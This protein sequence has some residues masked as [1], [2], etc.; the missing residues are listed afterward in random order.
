[1]VN[2][3]IERDVIIIGSERIEEKIKQIKLLMSELENSEP[4]LYKIQKLE[5]ILNEI[6]TRKE[7]YT[8]YKNLF[9]AAAEIL[10]SASIEARARK[11]DPTQRRLPE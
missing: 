8:T 7:L 2:P 11:C 3:N 5:T 9:N 10:I 6:G 4:D 1:M